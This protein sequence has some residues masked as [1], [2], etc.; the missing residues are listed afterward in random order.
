MTK[1]EDPEMAKAVTKSERGIEMDKQ[2][3]EEE[4]KKEQLIQDEK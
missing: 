1:V 3:N 4:R 2:Q